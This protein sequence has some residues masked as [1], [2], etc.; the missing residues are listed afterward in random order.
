MKSNEFTKCKKTLCE[1]DL[2][3]VEH[4][5]R[6]KLPTDLRQHYLRYNGGKPENTCWVFANREYDDIEVRDFIPIRYTKD[7]GDDPDFTAE[8]RARE[9]WA[10]NTLPNNLFPFAFDWG[11]NYFC[12][13][14]QTS[15]IYYYLRD[16]WS[17]KLSA[18]KNFEIN[19]RFMA[20]SLSEFLNGLVPGEDD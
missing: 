18:E 3:A 15:A 12:V 14:H 16:V 13:D 8:G 9:G 6:I 1:S 10:G 19:T 2:S 11:G 4:H 5:L 7:F 17:E 20:N